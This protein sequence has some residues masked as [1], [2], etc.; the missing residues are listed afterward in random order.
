MTTL[1]SKTSFHILIVFALLAF[2]LGS[3]LGVTPAYAAGI[4]TSAGMLCG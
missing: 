4:I 1:R 3:S 2:L